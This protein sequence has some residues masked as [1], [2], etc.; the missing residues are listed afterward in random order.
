V[1]A[2]FSKAM[3]GIEANGVRFDAASLT[4]ARAIWPLPV[5]AI[6]AYATR[7]RDAGTA[8]FPWVEFAIAAVLVGFGFNYLYQLAVANTSAAHVVLLQG[9]APLCL[10]A[11]DALFFRKPLDVPRRIALGLGVAGIACVA[12]A[13]TG[14]SASFAGDAIMGLWL[15][16]F[17]SYS[18]ITRRLTQRYSPLFVTAVAWGAGFALVALAGFRLVPFAIAHTLATPQLSALVIGGIVGASAIVA[19]AAHAAS[20]RAG[21]V[22]IATAGSQYGVIATGLL[23]SYFMLGEQLGPASIAGA[24]LLMAALACT[25]VPAR[26]AR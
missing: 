22:T 26:A 4:V 24:V 12:A 16:V 5:F 10:A 7:P 14:G 15:V 8:R 19:P 17:A 13:R 6:L 9:V 3:L 21:S 20:V 18:I 11:V 25:L 23:L 2:P 1:L